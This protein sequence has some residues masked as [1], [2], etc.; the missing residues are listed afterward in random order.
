MAAAAVA[1]TPAIPAWAFTKAEQLGIHNDSLCEA[2]RD[3]LSPPCQVVQFFDHGKQQGYIV[4]SYDLGEP[5]CSSWVLIPGG[6]MSNTNFLAVLY[7]LT[8]LYCFLGVA[9]IADV[10]MGAIEVITSKTYPV[11]KINPESGKEETVNVMVWNPTVA[12][13]SLMALGSSAPEILLAVIGTI[14]TLDATPDVL[15]PATI[16]GSA[17]FNLLVISAICIIAIPDGGTR[18]IEQMGVYIITASCSVFAYVWLWIVLGDSIVKAWEAWLTFAFFW[19]LLLAAWA[20]D[21]NFWRKSKIDTS[22]PSDLEL[23]AA[24]A[25]RGQRKSIM[26]PSD[27][28]N[29]T[30]EIAKQIKKDY[31]KKTAS[32]Q[33]ALI[34]AQLGERVRA[35]QPAPS[36]MQYRMNATRGMAGRRRMMPTEAGP[37]GD[38]NAPVSTAV[39]PENEVDQANVVSFQFRSLAYAVM[40]NAGKVLCYVERTGPIDCAA[41][42]L[43][44][45]R[46]ATANETMD[47]GGVKGGK[48]EFA[49]G[50]MEKTIS[51]DIVNDNQWEP[52]ETFFIDLRDPTTPNGQPNGINDKFKSTEVTILNDDSAGTL[53]FAFSDLMVKESE[54]HLELQVQRKN[55][56]DGDIKIEYKCL[57]GTALRGEDY[58]GESGEIV[59]KH[60]ESQKT[61]SIPIIDSSRDT[62]SLLTFEVLLTLPSDGAGGAV[63]SA[64]KKCT[65]TICH[66]D[67]FAG[68]LDKIS[69]ISHEKQQKFSVGSATWAEQFVGAM[70]IEG[71]VG[72]D[73]EISDPALFDFVM[74]GLTLPWKILFACCPPTDYAGGW[75][76]FGVAIAMIG[77]LTAVIGEFAALFGC[78]IG[79]KT[80][81]T[82]ITFVALGTSLPDTFA[83]KQAAVQHPAADPQSGTWSVPTQ[84]TSSSGSASRGSSARSTRAATTP[85]PRENSSS[86]SSCSSCA[87]SCVSSCSH[88][89]A[90]LSAPSSAAR[91]WRRT[92][93]PSFLLDSG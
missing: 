10:F 69:S 87:P 45:T 71:G 91:R 70:N 56:C 42:V 8:L 32:E 80:S 9:I 65:V 33:E 11:T 75:V 79:L 18:K 31:P 92:S 17:A 78:V 13:L 16:V 29:L 84:S 43:Y 19:I 81:V 40:E 62:E 85:T 93:A 66:D 35:S 55:G 89:A 64:L 25:S 59:F 73:G 47:Y 68:M 37:P 28:E 63:L 15:G 57:D 44:D 26:G 6:R 22:A 90:T 51:I 61:I 88:T 67:E 39:A 48:L 54:G 86:V 36:R 49:A 41:T 21:N 52:D 50:E 27:I 12:N 60:G 3:A 5:Y 72:E 83:S 46:D 82:A 20:A 14:S 74:H 53:A 4:E 77:A 76:C 1:Q 58:G 24:V 30:K 34:S 23:G 38:S 2:G 7:C